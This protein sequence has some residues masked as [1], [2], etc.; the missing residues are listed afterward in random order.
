[1][2]NVCVLNNYPL[3]K[4]VLRAQAGLVPGQHAWGVDALAAAGHVV[5]FAPFHEPGERNLLDRLSTATRHLVGQ[6]DQEAYA[7]RRIR[8]VGAFYCADQSSLAGLTLVRGLLPRARFVSVV[9]HPIGNALRRASAARHDVLICLSEAL[10]G[11]LERDLP[12]RRPQIVHVPWGPDLASTLYRPAGEANGV[13]SAGKSN[14]DLVTLA[15]ALRQTGADAVVYDLGGA[16]PAPPNQ[17]VRLVRPGDLEGTDPDSPGGYLAKRVIADIAA[18]SIVAIPV[19]DP[20]RLTGLTEALD[21]LALAK[22]IVATRSGYFPFDIE[23]VGCGVWVA[24]GDTDGWTRALGE[25]LSDAA[26][27]REM[28][29]AGRRFAERECNYEAFCVRL[30]ELIPG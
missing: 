8:G 6:L 3:E 29:A 14:R 5:D 1:M 7:V 27:R 19:R 17:S 9:H 23:A 12:G 20:D 26:A 28:G 22:P 30:S 18:A 11:E 10:R 13:V 25:L 2:A 16:L 15:A 21:A 4:M 24:A